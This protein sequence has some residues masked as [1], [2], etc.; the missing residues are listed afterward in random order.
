MLYSEILKRCDYLL[1][2]G[3]IVVMSS[4]GLVGLAQREGERLND[5]GR[6]GQVL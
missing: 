2:R 3:H 6:A 1:D 5:G 4:R